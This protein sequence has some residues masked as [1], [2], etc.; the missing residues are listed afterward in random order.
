MIEGN[1]VG[2]GRWGLILIA[3]A[4]TLAFGVSVGGDFVFDDVHSVRDN[5]AL[6]S[7]WNIPAF[8]VDVDLFSSWTAGYTDQSC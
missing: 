7:L 5:P 1:G 4:A 6:R 2:L 8:F 3:M